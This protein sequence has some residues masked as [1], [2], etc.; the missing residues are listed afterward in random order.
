M[1]ELL[2]KAYN[3]GVFGMSIGYRPGDW[4]DEEEL[5]YLGKIV[6]EHDGFLAHHG[7]QA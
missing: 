4:A 6:S 1:G 3:A 2:K 5:V 7:V